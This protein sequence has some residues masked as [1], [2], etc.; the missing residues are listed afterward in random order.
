MYSKPLSMLNIHPDAAPGLGTFDMRNSGFVAVTVAAALA[1]STVVVSAANVPSYPIGGGGSSSSSSAIGV[2]GVI[3]CA[4]GLIF[5][6]MNANRT[7][8]RPL[9]AKE[10]SFCGLSYWFNKHK[11]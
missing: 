4:G 10:A 2:W 7:Q 6:A 3:G 5:A 1:F 9:T 8:N 11:K